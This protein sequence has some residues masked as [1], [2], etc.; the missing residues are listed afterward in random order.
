MRKLRESKPSGIDIAVAV[1][2]VQPAL[3][4]LFAKFM[5]GLLAQSQQH[6]RIAHRRGQCVGVRQ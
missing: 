6:L 4:A 3:P 1:L 2:V 5:L